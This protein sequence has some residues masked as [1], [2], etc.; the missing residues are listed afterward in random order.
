MQQ[1]TNGDT[2]TYLS[3]RLD[4][5]SHF[6]KVNHTAT[7][8]IEYKHFIYAAGGPVAVH[9]VA[10]SGT[11]S[12]RYLHKDHLGSIESITDEA[13]NLVERLSY[14]AFGKRRQKTGA[15]GAVAVGTITAYGFTSQEM[16]DDI[17]LIHMNGRVYDPEVGRFIE[18]DPKGEGHTSQGLNR[19]SYVLNNPLSFT[20]PSGYKKF[21]QKKGFKTVAVVVIAAYTGGVAAS[22]YLGSSAAAAVSVGTS[23]AISGVTQAAIVN[24]MVSGA[25]MG[26]YQGYEQ[27]GNLEGTLRGAVKGGVIAALSAGMNGVA[28]GVNNAYG[29][30]IANTVSGSLQSAL[31]RGE[32]FEGS[33]GMS[34][35]GSLSSEIYMRNVGRPASWETSDGEG[36][37]KEGGMDSWYANGFNHNDMGLSLSV[38]DMEEGVDTLEWLGSEL[39][40]LRFVTEFI[41]GQN[42]GAALHDKWGGYLESEGNWNKVTN[43]GSMPVAMVVTAGALMHDAVILPKF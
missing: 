8:L 12:T 38:K 3:P 31:F 29:R 28:N 42:A 23:S 14:D 15:D 30:A 7:G 5:G 25:V 43:I 39:G 16:L 35:V 27:T 20:D 19:Y 1:I 24:G 34:F 36:R 6:E 40:P 21:W 2:T 11:S 37:L 9:T 26:A 18:A 13:G 22:A 41:P 32:S 17:G 10:S 4:T 33:L